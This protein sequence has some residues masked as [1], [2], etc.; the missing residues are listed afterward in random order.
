MKYKRMISLLLIL[1]S[2]YG[3]SQ[4]ETLPTEPSVSFLKGFESYWMALGLST[5]KFAN[6][7]ISSAEMVELLDKMVAYV[8]PDKLTEWQGMYPVLREST[9]SLNRH[10]MV[11]A[12]YLTLW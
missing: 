6:L 7:T 3:N 1:L 12:L 11:S 8:A 4:A 9:E 5:E 10:D 2:G